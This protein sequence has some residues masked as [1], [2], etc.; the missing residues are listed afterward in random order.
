MSARH[1]DGGDAELTATRTVVLPGDLDDVVRCG[2][3]P[4]WEQVAAVDAGESTRE[5]TTPTSDRWGA[6]VR[7]RGARDGPDEAAGDN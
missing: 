2:V 5:P 7:L 1:L 6:G 4:G 3:G